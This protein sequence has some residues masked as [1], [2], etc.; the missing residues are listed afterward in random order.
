MEKF[1]VSQLYAHPNWEMPQPELHEDVITYTLRCAAMLISPPK[2]EGEDMD[3]PC[4]VVADAIRR[5]ADEVRYRWMERKK[6][7]RK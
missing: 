4:E 5:L 6:G 1:H 3:T 7:I 2:I